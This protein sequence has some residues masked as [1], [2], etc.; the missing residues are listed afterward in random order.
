MDRI[1]DNQEAQED[2]AD[3]AQSR[4]HSV[5]LVSE[6]LFDEWKTEWNR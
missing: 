2:A 5:V 1:H 6:A 4:I 3:K